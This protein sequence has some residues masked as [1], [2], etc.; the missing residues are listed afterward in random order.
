M[1]GRSNAH[2][3]A[4]GGVRELLLPA[5]QGLP[6]RAQ[7]EYR[8]LWSAADADD[9]LAAAAQGQAVGEAVCVLLTFIACLFTF[10]VLLVLSLLLV[11]GQ[12]LLSMPS[13][14]VKFQKQWLRQ[15]EVSTKNAGPCT[16]SAPQ[17]PEGGTW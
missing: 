11:M 12:H 2:W 4:L 8:A 17:P 10:A 15:E 6:G 14:L 9:A 1:F 3:L 16:L 13:P 7:A 5:L